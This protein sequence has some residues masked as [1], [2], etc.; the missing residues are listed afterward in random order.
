[1]K[2]KYGIFSLIYEKKL[3]NELYKKIIHQ[4]TK[5]FIYLYLHKNKKFD[6]DQKLCF[7]L[8]FSS[9]NPSLGPSHS[10]DTQS[11]D[12][13][14]PKHE[15]DE[16]LVPDPPVSPL[17]LQWG[18]SVVDPVVAPVVEV[19]RV[20]HVEIVY[21]PAENAVLPE[22]VDHHPVE[23]LH[24]VRV[25]SHCPSVA[26]CCHGGPVDDLRGPKT[27][28]PHPLQHLRPKLGCIIGTVD[29]TTDARPVYT[30]VQAGVHD[31]SV[32]YGFLGEVILQ[33]LSVAFVHQ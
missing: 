30:V 23:D 31:Y 25:E 32:G 1:M 29:E 7:R 15:V 22:L 6:H 18:S 3:Q 21:D 16:V 17:G 9:K 13:D 19:P 26:A 4:S 33:L 12:K 2:G 10:S 8:R 11:V 28:L 24:F 20:G 14:V 27:P 5:E